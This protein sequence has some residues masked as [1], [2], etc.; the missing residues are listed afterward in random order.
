M[1]RLLQNLNAIH[2]AGNEVTVNCV[3]HK[4]R[5]PPR[6]AT[7]PN[8][9]T[10][11]C[12]GINITSFSERWSKFL[13]GAPYYAVWGEGGIKKKRRKS[14]GGNQ[15]WRVHFYHDSVIFML[16]AEKYTFE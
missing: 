5:K 8:F 16:L 1:L 4:P 6:Y 11:I 7:G 14:S 10:E 12:S 2:L 9:E 3:L 13:R 15:F